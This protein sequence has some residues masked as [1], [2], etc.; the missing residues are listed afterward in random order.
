MPVTRLTESELRAWQALIH[1]HHEVVSR[2]DEELRQAHGVTFA[3]YDVLLRLARAPGRA[4]RMG[5]LAARVLLTPSG[6]TRLVQ[7]LAS[8][9]L[10]RRDV[11]AS[12][13]RAILATL[14]DRGLD[15]IRAA[16][17]IHVRGI[18]EHFSGQLSPSQLRAVASALE[19]IVGPH[20]PH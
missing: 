13:G 2:L 14:T 10:I 17:R 3:E 20:V 8:R 12:D 6:I 19:T 5:D 15:L 1:A 7:R 16:A 9:G 18:R 11:D 4:L